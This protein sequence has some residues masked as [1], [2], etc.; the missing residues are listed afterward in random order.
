MLLLLTAK[1]RR[2]YDVAN[3]LVCLKLVQKVQVSSDGR[4]RKPAFQ[5]VGPD[6]SASPPP[7]DGLYQATSHALGHIWLL[8]L[9]TD[10]D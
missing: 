4:A 6:V 9:M 3:V 5:Y 2:L 8:I 7:S 1:L 10:L